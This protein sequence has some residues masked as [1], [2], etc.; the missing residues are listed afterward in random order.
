MKENIEIDGIEYVRKDSISIPVKNKYPIKMIRCYSAGVFFGEL[1][2]RKGKEVTLLNARRVWYWDGAASLSQLAQ[3]GTSKPD[4]CKFPEPV[5]EI[6]LTDVIEII[7]VT[8][9]AFEILKNIKIWKE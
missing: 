4:N 2:E 3:S 6:I 5:S 7:T 9:K 1:K 8:E